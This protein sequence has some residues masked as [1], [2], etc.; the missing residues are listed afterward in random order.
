MWAVP[1]AFLLACPVI[2]VAMFNYCGIGGCNGPYGDYLG[3]RDEAW[4]Y[5][6]IVGAI[7]AV[8]LT[9]APWIWPLPRRIL[10]SVGIGVV[11][12]LVLALYFSRL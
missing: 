3:G 11:A 4:I 10:L 1:V 8:V 6:C 12:G 2:L 5:N 7:F 9:L